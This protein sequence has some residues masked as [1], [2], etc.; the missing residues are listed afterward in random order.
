M[1]TI[2]LITFEDQAKTYEALSQLK[3]IS[4]SNTLELKQAAI[5]QKSDDGT[6]YA[7]KD[8]L[9]YES[10]NRVATGGIIGMVVG[11]LGGPLGV[12]CGWVVGDLAGLGTNYVKNKKTTTIFDSVAKELTKNE[13]GLLLYMDE[14]DNTLLDTMIVDKLNGTIERFSYDSVQEDLETAKKHLN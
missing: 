8:G 3:Q 6:G 7:I 12:L 10:G 11:I 4:K 9:D 1:K 2:A 5:L 14:T 13:L